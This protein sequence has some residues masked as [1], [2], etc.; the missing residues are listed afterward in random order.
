MSEQKQCADCAKVISTVEELEALPHG[1]IVR[2][3]GL[4]DVLTMNRED[5]PEPF[6]QGDDG[7]W[8]RCNNVFSFYRAD[9][10]IVEEAP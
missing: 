2:I 6:F 5:L 1:T 7:S 3:P 4:D 10:V 9:N 8:L